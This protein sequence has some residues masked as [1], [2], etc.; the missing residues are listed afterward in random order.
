MCLKIFNYLAH[1]YAAQL[2][3][4]LRQ[5]MKVF[6][7]VKDKMCLRSSILLNVFIIKISFR[8]HITSKKEECIFS[9]VMQYLSVGNG[10]AFTQL[11]G[12]WEHIAIQYALYV[13]H[14]SKTGSP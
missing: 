1:V 14:N 8:S 9:Q 4:V 7:F 11:F 2:L 3:W 10:S 12:R 13:K 5:I 6:L